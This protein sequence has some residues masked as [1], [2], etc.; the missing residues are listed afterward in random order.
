M[1]IQLKISSTKFNN[2][3]DYLPD[4]EIPKDK[5]KQTKI[6]KFIAQTLFDCTLDC[7]DINSSQFYNWIE[8]TT[9]KKFNLKKYE[10]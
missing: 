2:L 4:C 6:C 9:A 5:K 10:I 1:K 8:R 7:W 3:L